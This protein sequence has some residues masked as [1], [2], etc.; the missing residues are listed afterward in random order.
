MSN[1]T[2]RLSIKLAKDKQVSVILSQYSFIYR[3]KQ[4]L[5]CGL[6]IADP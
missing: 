1:T 6:E 3:N 5:A 2:T 4:H